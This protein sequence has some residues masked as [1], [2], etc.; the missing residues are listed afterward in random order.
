[1]LQCHFQET[2]N[3]SDSISWY[4]HSSQHLKIHLNESLRLMSVVQHEIQ[5]LHKRVCQL[6]LN[7]VV[8]DT[9]SHKYQH[10]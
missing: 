1:M 9:Q 3:Y 6:L 10:S 4:Q 8:Q 2:L 5:Q 7:N